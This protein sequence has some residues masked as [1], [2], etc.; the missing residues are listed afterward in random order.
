MSFFI[1]STSGLSP[2]RASSSLKRVRM[3]RR[4]WDTPASMV[5]RCSMVRSTRVFISM[6]AEAGT[7]HLLGAARPE[8]RHVAALAEALDRVGEPQD[9]PDLVAQE[10]DRDGDAAPARCPPSTTGRSPSS[11]HRRRC[12]ARRRACTASSSWMRISTRFERPTVSI[13]NGRPICLRTSCGQRLVE[14]REERLRPDRRQRVD[15]QEIDREP[16]PLLGDATQRRV[17]AVRRKLLRRSIERGDVLGHRRRQPPR[18]RVP[19]PLHEHEG[20]DRLQDHHRRDDD[21]QR[22]GVEPL[23]QQALDRSVSTR[24]HRRRARPAAM[25]SRDM[26][27]S[28]LVTAAPPAGS[29][30]RA[31]SA[32]TAD[33]RDR[34]RSCGAAG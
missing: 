12:G 20:D 5:V 4:S 16:E 22:A 3:V 9:R 33:W 11:T 6:K 19:V 30:C 14:Q 15:G 26:P 25:R 24:S 31:R 18:H 7:A 13:Q 2:I 21:D 8:V 23:R 10:Q 34:S 29:R 32:R 27:T 17:V 28:R 1:A